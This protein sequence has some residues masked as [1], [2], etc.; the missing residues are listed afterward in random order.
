MTIETLIAQMTAELAQARVAYLP[1]PCGADAIAA[2]ERDFRQRYGI[3]LAPAYTRLLRC[4]NGVS[5]NGLTIWP[6]TEQPLFRETLI[7]ANDD[8]RDSFSA[9]FIYYGQRDEELY[10][11][12]LKAAV[13][14]AIEFV[15]KPVWERFSDAQ[16]MFEFML[17]RAWDA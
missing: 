14:C 11:Y 16:T 5:F 9:D 2:L 15:G 8:L 10:V 7:Q 12:D 13:Y 4:A 3:E 6:A 1:Q 17:E